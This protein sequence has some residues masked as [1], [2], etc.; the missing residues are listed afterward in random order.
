MAPFI[1]TRRWVQPYIR[2]ILA[3][4]ALAMGMTSAFMLISKMLGM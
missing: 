3:L 4:T 1:I 2:H